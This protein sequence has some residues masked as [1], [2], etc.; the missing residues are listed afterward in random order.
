MTCLA[1]KATL[2]WAGEP[3]T[4]LASP[5][6]L[7]L[8]P[9]APAETPPGE[10][11]P[12][13]DRLSWALQSAKELAHRP[14]ALSPSTS[15]RRRTEGRQSRRP[16]PPAARHR[17]RARPSWTWVDREAKGRPVRSG[18]FRGEPENDRSIV[19]AGK[20]AVE[21]RGSVER[22]RGRVDL[23]AGKL[24]FGGADDLYSP[25]LHAQPVKPGR[26]EPAIRSGGSWSAPSDP[27]VRIRNRLLETNVG[28][29]ELSARKPEQ[30]ELQ[31]RRGEGQP[32]PV[33]ARRADL[34]FAQ[35]EVRR[36]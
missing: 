7:I 19:R 2:I 29:P 30:L 22:G 9:P 31:S 34:A 6:A 13:P 28:E 15:L 3:K 35:R 10:G 26:V 12:E 21:T 8:V 1:F 14:R 36:R 17:I 33:L 20:L 16:D 23:D 27:R 32:R 18:F 24:G 5:A 25:I 4:S 11:W